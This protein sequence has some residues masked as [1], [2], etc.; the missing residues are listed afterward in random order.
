MASSREG[1]SSFSKSQPQPQYTRLHITPLNPSLLPS[2]LPATALPMAQNISYHSI[3]TFPE[4]NYGFVDLPEMEAEKIKKKLNGAILKRTK[5]K[6]EEARP[7]KHAKPS[8]EQPSISAPLEE[9]GS[10]KLS[11]KRKRYPDTLPA[12]ELQDRK[13]RRGWTEPI[14]T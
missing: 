14:A 8:E 1:N 6:I 2:I 12:I 7:P 9:H 11:K 3:S 10:D 4:K 13:V 5:V